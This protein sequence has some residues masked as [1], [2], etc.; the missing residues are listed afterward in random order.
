MQPGGI[1]ASSEWNYHSLQNPPVSQPR[2]KEQYCASSIYRGIIPAKNINNRDFAI[3][4]AV[5]GPFL[6]GCCVI[7]MIGILK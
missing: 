5:V 7:F 2:E 3:N 4:G 6:L 1:A